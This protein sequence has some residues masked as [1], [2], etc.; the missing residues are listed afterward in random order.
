MVLQCLPE[1]ERR[2]ALTTIMA[3]GARATAE[4]PLAWIGLEWNSDRSEVQLRLTHWTGRDDA[5]GTSRILATCH[6]YG[7]WIDWRG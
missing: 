6:A 3:A 7:S 1:A 5:G 4:R 2:A